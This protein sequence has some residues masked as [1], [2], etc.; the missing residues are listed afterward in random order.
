MNTQI[1]FNINSKLKEK[2]MKKAQN[3]GIP[4]SS[5]LKLA[6][7][8]FVDGQLDIGL[9]SQQKISAQTRAM[10][11]REIKDIKEGKDISPSFNS[12]NEAVAYLK[13]L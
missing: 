5:V 2:A 6:T 12:T 8:A 7:K 4:F 10:L 1:I 11:I 3:E 13:S 9:V